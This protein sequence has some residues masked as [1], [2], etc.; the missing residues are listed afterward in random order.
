MRVLFVHTAT[1]PPLGADTWVQVQI[2]RDLDRSA[3]EVHVACAT[4]TSDAPTPTFQALSGIADIHLHPVDFG[5]ELFG[6]TLGG[7]A[8]GLF[9]ALRAIPSL[10]RLVL[11]VRRQRVQVIHTTTAPVTRW[12]A[13][14]SHA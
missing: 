3:Y 6:R 7:K 5:P 10:A 13:C 9:G 8:R 12:P 1:L 4:G 11:F 14:F 2:I